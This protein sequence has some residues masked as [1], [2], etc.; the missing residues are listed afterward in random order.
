MD[1][2][3]QFFQQTHQIVHDLTEFLCTIREANLQEDFVAMAKMLI[4]DSFGSSS[5]ILQAYWDSLLNSK[6]PSVDEEAVKDARQWF[7]PWSEQFFLANAHFMFATC[8]G[9]WT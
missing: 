5:P 3:K 2:L 1:R 6:D 9:H 7:K 4:Q 8:G